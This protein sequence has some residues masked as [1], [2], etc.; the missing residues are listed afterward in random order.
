MFRALGLLPAVF[1]TRGVSVFMGAAKVAVVCPKEVPMKADSLF[2]RPLL[3]ENAES[4]QIFGAYADVSSHHLAM[5]VLDQVASNCP[6][7]SRLKV[8]WWS[9]EMIESLGGSELA[10]RAAL[11]AD[12]VWLAI[13]ALEQLP[14]AVKG[15]AELWASRRTKAECTLVALLHCESGC[16]VDHAPAL[17]YLRSLAGAA[18]LEFVARRFDSDDPLVINQSPEQAYQSR[19]MDNSGREETGPF[20]WWG[21]NE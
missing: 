7:L 9:F 20:G 14:S 4:L 6:V 1:P 13:S 10:V 11:A 8:A 19:W 15:W 18:S 16:D 17:S 21:L 12:M 3:C 2:D 5:R